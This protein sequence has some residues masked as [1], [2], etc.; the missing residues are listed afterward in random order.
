[1][2]P[3][4]TSF[5]DQSQDQFIPLA[6]PKDHEMVILADQLDWDLL[7]AIGESRRESKGMSP[8]G[9]KPHHRPLM[10]AMVVR[11]LRKCNFREAEDLIKNYLPARYMCNLQG[12]TWNPDHNTIWEYEMMLGEMGLK[13]VNDYVLKEA[14][15]FG[16]A[17]PRGLCSDTTAQE[18]NIP[19]PNEVGHMNS[20]MKSLKK[21]METLLSSGKG[22]GK[23]LVGS[24]K[25]K[26][27]GVAHKVRH[28][29]L[30]AKTKE[31]R[32]QINKELLNLTSGLMGDLGQWL[33][34]IDIQKNQI[35]GSGKRA[36]GNLTEIYLNMSQ[37]FP[38]IQ[39]WIEKGRVVQGK[40]VSLFNTN[41]KAI[42]REKSGKP[43][44]FGLK[45]GINQIRGGYVSLFMLDNMMSHDSKYAVEAIKEHIQIF[46]EAPRDFG[47]DRA[48]WSA[49]HMQEIEDLGVKNLGIA[50]KGKAQWKVG[51]RVQDRMIRERAQVEGKI[52]TLKSQGFNKPKSKTNPAVRQSALRAGLCFNL[53][54]F[55]KDLVAMN[56]AA[57]ISIC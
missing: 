17:D 44:E 26:L 5:L 29:R 31:A 6:V 27:S 49:E 2:R 45:W 38:Q 37:M 33:G 12:S 25:E 13:E 3:Y 40:I 54:R 46:G 30:F 8:R 43:V 14:A 56:T 22:L 39:T 20:F 4:Q 9:L 57:A 19:Y 36:L 34:Q 1:M 35:K 23:K 10:G 28:H 16:F 53:K 41:F 47:F 18:A 52:G 11:S 32:N 51:P 15:S 50:P 48:A 24:M 55:A 7:Q 21:N 42:S